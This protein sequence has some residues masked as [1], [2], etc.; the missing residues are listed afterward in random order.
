[1]FFMNTNYKIKFERINNKIGVPQSG[2]IYIGFGF[3]KN[4]LITHYA[5]RI[6]HLYTRPDIP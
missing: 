1:M 5:F 2:T 3:S 6:T 4:S